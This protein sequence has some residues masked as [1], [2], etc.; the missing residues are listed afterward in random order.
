MATPS[1]FILNEN[2]KLAQ[3]K[4]QNSRGQVKGKAKKENKNISTKDSAAG[5]KVVTQE[6]LLKQADEP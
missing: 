5:E 3:P 4:A 1:R 2:R 6:E